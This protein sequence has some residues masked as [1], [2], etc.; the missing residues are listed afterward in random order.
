MLCAMYGDDDHP[1]KAETLDKLGYELC[2]LGEASEAYEQAESAASMLE[3]LYGKDDPRYAIALTNIGLALTGLGRTEQA[4]AAHLQ[5]HAILLNVYGC[6]HR[7]VR[8]TAQRGRT[9]PVD[10]PVGTA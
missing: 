3:R 5:A 1:L 8:L 4:R 9:S 6:D 2:L 7:L 10:R